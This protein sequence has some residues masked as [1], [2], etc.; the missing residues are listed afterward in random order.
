MLLSQIVRLSTA[1]AMPLV[2]AVV[3]TAN[4]ETLA[5]WSFDEG[6]AGALLSN[7]IGVPPIATDSVGGLEIRRV[8]GTQLF[9]ND[10]PN[11]AA[12][13]RSLQFST[14]GYAT[15]VN[16]QSAFDFG[17]N[18]PFTIE[19]FIRYVSGREVI[20]NRNN[21]GGIRGWSIH[22]QNGLFRFGAAD[23]TVSN[24][25]AFDDFTVDDGAW[26]HFAAVREANGDLRV[27]LDYIE[28]TNPALIVGT[29][30]VPGLLDGSGVYLGAQQGTINPFL[31]FL[32]EV[33]FSD[34]ALTP[35][36]FIQVPEPSTAS[37]LAFGIM[38][39]YFYRRRDTFR[40]HR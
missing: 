26:H 9:S 28:D 7:T 19:G 21:S 20:Y 36:Q 15:I 17:A 24:I 32:D 4:A 11:P 37:L 39:L 18:Q 22:V 31:G 23:D 38:A 6:A 1:I 5:L 35:D 33:R 40:R 3:S 34:V 25:I 30:T 12:G 8:A 10:I 27:Y 14:S 2:L 13:P 29:G 16:S